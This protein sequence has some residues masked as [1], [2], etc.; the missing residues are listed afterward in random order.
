MNASMKTLNGGR[1]P[2]VLLN[3]SLKADPVSLPSGQDVPKYF[4][5]E[6]DEDSV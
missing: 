3:A 5:L 6:E 2:G 1:H 4:R